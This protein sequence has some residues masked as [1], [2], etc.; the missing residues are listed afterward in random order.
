MQ[1][2][3]YSLPERLYVTVFVVRTHH[4]RCHRYACGT[5]FAQRNAV[6]SVAQ[7]RVPHEGRVYGVVRCEAL[8]PHTVPDSLTY[9][10]VPR[11]QDE[12]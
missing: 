9:D 7:F 3:G 12:S 8:T 2:L 6:L 1:R 5:C 11:N 10:V 4:Q